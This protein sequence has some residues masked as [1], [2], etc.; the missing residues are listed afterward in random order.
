LPFLSVNR[1]RDSLLADRTKIVSAPYPSNNRR[2]LK[3]LSEVPRTR[4]FPQSDLLISTRHI[5]PCCITVHGIK[6]V[7]DGDRMGRA[8]YGYNKFHLIMIAFR[9]GWIRDCSSAEYD[10]RSRLREIPGGLA[11]LLEPHFFGMFRVISSNAENAVDRVQRRRS[12]DRNDRLW[13]RVKNV[14]WMRTGAHGRGRSS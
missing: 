2:L 11:I 1:E 4:F 12:L 7:I 13:R 8:A 3:S 14:F 5:H 10:G 9:L 6:R